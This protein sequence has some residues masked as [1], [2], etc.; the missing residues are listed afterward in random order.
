MADHTLIIR[1]A[2]PRAD[3]SLFQR[4]GTHQR[5]VWV[6]R[7]KICPD[8]Q[9]LTDLGAVVQLEHRYHRVLILCEIGSLEGDVRGNALLL[10][11][12][13]AF[14]QQKHPHAPTVR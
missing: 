8:R 11:N 10:R 3:D 14:F 7:L 1:A 6:E 12:V 2:L 9:G 5:W 4:S 13:D